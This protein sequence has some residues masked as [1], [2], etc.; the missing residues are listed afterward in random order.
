MMGNLQRDRTTDPALDAFMA[1]G[2]DMLMSG[3]AEQ[4]ATGF[5]ARGAKADRLRALARVALDFWTWR[6][7]D[8]EGLSDRQAA[9]L[10]A[11]TVAALA[12]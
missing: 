5:G 7:L 12:G 6:R 3:L 4:L 10:M 9:E 8:A 11:D 1:G 2:T